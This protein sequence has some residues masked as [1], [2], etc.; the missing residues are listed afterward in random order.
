MTVAEFD[1]ATLA[2]QDQYKLLVGTV[3]PRPIALVTTIGQEGVNAA[4]F[5]FFN[6][7]G[8][9]PPMLAFSVGGRGGK[10]KDT[11]A[12]LREVPEFVVHVVSYAIR[13][14]MNVC[15]IEYPRGVDELAQAGFTA[16]PSRK[17]RPPRIAEAPA[18]F[19]CRVMKI[20]EVGEGPHHLVIGEVVHFHFR[21]G[22]VN[23]RHH[24]DIAALDPIGRLGGRGGYTR[25][26]DRFEMPRLPLPG[27]GNGEG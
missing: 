3:T 16:V 10:A 5:S 23:E 27:G 18:A 26:T 12:N 8:S 7:L 24:V 6:A 22:I 20:V 9:P 21:D 13:E 17:V 4:P 1:A 25:V 2:P 19:E 14:Q 15:G 11:V